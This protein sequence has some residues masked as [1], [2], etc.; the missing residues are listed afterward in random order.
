MFWECVGECQ[1]AG[2]RDPQLWPLFELPRAVPAQRNDVHR[3]DTAVELLL[4]GVHYFQIAQ[5]DS[6]DIFG[7]AF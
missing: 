7:L 3:Q 1:L 6:Q 4:N 2:H 5:Q